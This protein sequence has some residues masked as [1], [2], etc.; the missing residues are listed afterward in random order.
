[1]TETTM[2]ADTS[3]R[4]MRINFGQSLL[5]FSFGLGG[6]LTG[7]LLVLFFDT[8]SITNAPWALIL[9]PGVLSIRGAIGGL[10]SGH[11]A[12]GLHLGTVRAS[13]TKNTKDFYILLRA[14]VV[15]S[16]ISGISIGI[17]TSIFGV[18]L[19]N[20]T[21]NDLIMLLAVVIATMALSIL[22]ISP[23]TIVFSI[24]SFRLGFDPDVIVYPI[25][26]T[27][28]DIINVACYI[29]NLNVFFRLPQFGS[30]LIGIINFVFLSATIYILIKGLKE[31][32]FV[33]IIREFILTLLL[34]TFIVNITGIFLGNIRTHIHNGAEL[35]LIYPALITT[36]GAVGSIIGSTATTKLALGFIKPSV[37]SIKQH[38]NEIVGS[39]IASMVMFAIYSIISSLMSTV[40][41]LHTLM[42]TLAQ[43]LA[44]NIFAVSIMAIIAYM[45]AVFTYR[46]RLNP[47]NFVIPI[48]SSL[49]DGVTTIS[50]LIALTLLI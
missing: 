47:D 26:S 27:I 25:I 40:I 34:I 38:T 14:V 8:F 23:I 16:L 5:S 36:I 24:L 28:A 18:F 21:L 17:G 44:T 10:F 29:F 1:M 46:Q 11:L 15:L 13:Y 31:E 32:F 12:T 20:A 41:T 22:F 3:L 2:T 35:Y 42:I 45:T 50:L 37:S 33:R 4:G 6:L 43:L 7:G 19:W 39:W 49:A 48:E 9:F 30:Y